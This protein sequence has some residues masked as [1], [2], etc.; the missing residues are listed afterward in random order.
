LP[1]QICD[2]FKEDSKNKNEIRKALSGLHEKGYIVLS[3]YD[4]EIKYH[5]YLDLF[6]PKINPKDKE[7]GQYYLDENG[8]PKQETNSYSVV[9]VEGNRILHELFYRLA[10]RQINVTRGKDSKPKN[11]YY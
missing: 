1:I 2:V 4:S 6:I 7:R 5:T 8:K 11:P 9:S 3:Y 10:C